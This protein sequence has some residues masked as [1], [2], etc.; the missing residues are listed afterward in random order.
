VIV[1]VNKWDAVEKTR[2]KREFEREV[3]DHLKFLDYAPIVFLSARSGEGVPGLFR[4]IREVYEAAS[5]RIPTSELNRFVEDLRFEER[6]IFYITQHSI[7]PP[8][9]AVFTDRGGPLH[10]SHERYLINQ[11]R[12]RFGFRGTPITLKTRAKGAR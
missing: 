6:K 1:C 10:F 9:F 12:R 7:R 11:I 8:A 3:R 5:R 2:G 4:L